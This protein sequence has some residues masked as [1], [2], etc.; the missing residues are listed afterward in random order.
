MSSSIDQSTVRHVA[1]LARLKVT[2]DEVAQFA[3]Q[4]SNILTYVELLNEVDTTNVQPT[5]HAGAVANAF[6]EDVPVE[7]WSPEQALANAPAKNETYFKVPKVLDQE[8]A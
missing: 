2:D 8:N 5:A 6:R 7:S 1:H 3:D 4:L